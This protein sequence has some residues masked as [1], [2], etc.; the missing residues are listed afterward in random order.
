MRLLHV[1]NLELK[2]FFEP[3]IP[4]YAILSHTWRSDEITLQDLS[5]ILKCS[6]EGSHHTSKATAGYRKIEQACKQAEQDGFEWAWVDTCCI[7][8]TSSAELSEA[9]NSMFR[10]YQNSA[11]C[12]AYLSDVEDGDVLRAAD[13]SFR[14]SRW[15]T[16]GWTLQELL[17][18]DKVIFFSKSWATI[19]DL[20]S[21]YDVVEDITRISSEYLLGRSV[22]SAS[23]SQKMAWASQRTT[24]RLE[25]MS[26]C[27][28]GMFNVNMPLLYGEGEKAFIR[29]QQEIIEASND[30][31]LFIWGFGHDSTEASPRENLSGEPKLLATS[32]SDFTG[33][34]NIVQCNAWVPKRVASFEMTKTGLRKY[35]DY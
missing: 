12:Y 14:K 33:C 15:F 30:Q 17:A 24:T 13:S 8:K 27:L 7:D 5:Q 20:R 11:I 9:I 2:E 19:G 10:W 32:P 35:L 25:D 28:L 4:P 16:R 1:Q 29:L 34:E 22:L 6:R 26:Y 23:V 21:L 31:T 18:P 3:S